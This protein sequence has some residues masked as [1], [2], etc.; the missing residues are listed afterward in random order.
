MSH[1]TGVE[2]SQTLDTM[3]H[4]V[5]NLAL[6]AIN[7]EAGSLMLVANKRGILQIKARLG[8]P[9]P[10]RKREQVYKIGDNSI[11]SWVVKN[12]RSYLC[13]NVET[14]EFFA[15]SRSGRNFSSLLSTPVVYQDK[16]IAVINADAPE[17]NHFTDEHQKIL[18]SVAQQV[19][20]PIAERISIL[21]ALA[22]VG[23]ELSRLPSEGG[24]ES[25]LAKIAQLAVRS[26][27]A[28]MVTLYQY[29]QDKDVF[30][31]EGVGPT[32]YPGVQDS[33][34]MRR[35]MFP[36]D[37]PWTV[38]KERRSGFYS[39]VEKEAFLTHPVERPGDTLRPRFV[40]REGIKSM[41]ALLLPFRAAEIEDEE[42]VGVMFVNYRTHHEFNIDEISALATFADYAAV[43]ILNARH[44]QQ[45]RA[46]QM[47]IAESISA[48][49]AHR[50]GNLAGT[51]RVAV[52]FLRD[53]IVDLD[54][55]TKRHL[56][57][58]ERESNVL[59]DLAERIARPFKETGKTSEPT[60][61]EVG[62]ILTE[63]IDRIT[64]DLGTIILVPEFASDLP[65][66]S[67]VD[68]QLRQV[69]HDII[70]NSLEAMSGQESGKLNVRGYFDR[71][72][73]HVKIEISDTGPGIHDD[74]RR[75]LFTP[76][77]STKRGKLG[78]G[79]WWCRTF[80]QASGGD[81]VL[82]D[83]RSGEGTTF[84]IEVPVV[85][86]DVKPLEE[87]PV[88]DIL[89]VDDA[90]EWRE[91]LAEAVTSKG[92]TV[93]TADSYA[94]ASH[95]LKT[96]HFRLA[97]VDMRLEDADPGNKD[98]LRVLSDIDK[99]NLDTRV[100]IVTVYGTEQD[101][102]VASRSPRFCAFI[103]KNRFDLKQFNQLVE[104]TISESRSR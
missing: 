97:I 91:L 27:G 13:R 48:N 1:E 44:E 29:A 94:A 14:D 86:G 92:Y 53:R 15:P 103:Y 69:I 37:V 22:E 2:T 12:K 68:F 50:M 18:E 90:R 4:Q 25:V 88:K 85:K 98:G 59:L 72:S 35:K 32:I 39:D 65:R 63:E 102:I 58:I 104:Q 20:A 81:V 3:L 30:P 17:I 73:N 7:A 11:A 71:R 8:S 42:V 82:K 87:L 93:E 56:D 74:I 40:K 67:S 16:V 19:S 38:V 28:D 77:I 96:N 76:G 6:V 57:R 45:R 78:I 46:E 64:P 31:V 51:S 49:F 21:D 41:A 24:V 43:A 61:I 23:V 47:R 89:V 75:Q 62:N 52:Q 100:I 101:Q 66:V 55:I 9:R 79:L 33:S 95:M 34:H 60:S 36:G 26:L 70:S 54:E 5:L 10:G 84:V 80:M 83:T 99:D